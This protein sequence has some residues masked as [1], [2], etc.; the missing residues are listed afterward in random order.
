MGPFPSLLL[1][2]CLLFLLLWEDVVN[3]GQIMLGEDEVQQPSDHD[4]A[5]DLWW[6]FRENHG[7]KAPNSGSFSSLL[8]AV[9][10]DFFWCL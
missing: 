4:E 9:F 3:P 10:R 6:E 7:L 8:S 2:L 1:L 5:Q